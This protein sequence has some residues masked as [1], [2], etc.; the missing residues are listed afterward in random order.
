MAK[1]ATVIER[2]RALIHTHELRVDREQAA[3][4][5]RLNVLQQELA[6]PAG[7]G[8]FGRLLGRKPTRAR[9]LCGAASGAAN[10]C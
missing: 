3:A 7:G 4:A 9:A 1:P 6:A 5:E 2:Y 8:F 10:R